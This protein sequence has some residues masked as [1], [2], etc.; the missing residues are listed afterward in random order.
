LR[1]VLDTSAYSHFRGNHQEVVDRIAEAAVVYVPA[2]VLGELEAAF[3]LGGRTAD[4]RAVLEAFL[5][6]DFVGVLP[7]TRDVARVYGS[8]F[9][10]LREAGTPIPVN[11]IWIAAATI[12]AGAHLVTFDADFERIERLEQTVLVA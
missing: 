7:V 12:D 1:I 5:G 9:A 4:N 2:T 8:L 3:S 10:E 11:D 6:E